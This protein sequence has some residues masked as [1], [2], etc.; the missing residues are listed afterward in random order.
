MVPTAA[1]HGR[2]GQGHR[3]E[4][5]GVGRARPHHRPL[6]LEAAQPRQR[7]PL[8][9][10]DAV[11]HDHDPGARREAV[12]AVAARTSTRSSSRP[13][14]GGR[15]VSSYQLRTGIRTVR[16][17]GDGRLLLNGKRVH[18][19]GVGVHEESQAQGFAV[20]NAFRR[21][22]VLRGQGGRRDADA[23]ALPAAPLHAGAGRQG[24]RPHLVGG[25]GL[26]AQHAEPLQARRDRARGQGGREEHRRQPERTR[27]CCCG[28][29][30]TSSPR[31][32]GARR[33]PT[34]RTPSAWRSRSTRA[35]PS[36]SRWPATRRSPASRAYRPLDVIGINDYFGW[37]PGPG[38]ADLRP[39]QALAPT[40]TRSASATRSRRSW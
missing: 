7:Q 9:R 15:K 10:R 4:R 35:G 34:S 29:S 27:R 17:A 6:R 12:D 28:R 14:V 21:R 23:H 38:G 26:H 3:P 33:P 19:R 22:L 16:V 5:E 24:R 36:A 11:V 37:Y 32:P 30:R 1:A 20:D 39:Q 18:L 8:R 2:A 31:A 40:S 25:P 13:R